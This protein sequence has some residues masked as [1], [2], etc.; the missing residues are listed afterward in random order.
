MKKIIMVAVVAAT[1][2]GMFVGCSRQKTP[3]EVATIVLDSIFKTQDVATLRRYSDAD[4]L[5]DNRDYAEMVKAMES[6]AA[7]KETKK[8]LSAK[9]A[10]MSDL[11]YSFKRE[12]DESCSAGVKWV[13][14]SFTLLLKNEEMVTRK[15]SLALV[16]DEWRLI[17]LDR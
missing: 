11:T 1:V 4:S 6:G 5:K 14:L 17:N 7:A 3:E 9:G 13:K 2:G 8:T 12:V 10:T 16:E 15:M